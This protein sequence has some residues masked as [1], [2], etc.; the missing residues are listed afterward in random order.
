MSKSKANA[1]LLFAALLWGLGNVAQKTVLADLGPFSSV[2]I[3][4]LIG[5]LVIA[6]LSR[7]MQPEAPELERR[8]KAMAAFII[9]MF[10]FAMVLMQIGF[11]LTSVTNAGF[12]INISSVLTPMLALALLKRRSSKMIWLAASTVVV[13]A[14]LMCG[15]PSGGWQAGD[16]VCV[17][18]AVCFALWTIYL[19][20]FV[21]RYGRAE[22]L[23]LAQFALTG[24]VCTAIGLARETISL[25]ALAEAMPELLL[26]GIGSTG[27]AFY[28]Q[29][30]AQKFTSA[31]EAVIIVSAEAVFGALF[32]HL[33]LG[34]WIGGGAALGALLI[35]CGIAA[36][37]FPPEWDVRMPPV[38]KP[39]AVRRRAVAAARART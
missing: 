25:N 4:C 28:V 31:S 3:R 27:V 2:G 37:Q 22:A 1:L 32:G 26:L 17:A 18:C 19:G 36:M 13:G 35:M 16:L 8:G 11:G 24:A 34:E 33:L 39:P 10:A 7:R 21:Q 23:S 5:A 29:A 20:E 15:G 14:A 6:P 12:L 9:L 38:L 30:V